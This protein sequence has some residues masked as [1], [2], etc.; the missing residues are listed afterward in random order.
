MDHVLQLKQRN[1]PPVRYV[2]EEADGADWLGAA[3]R[4]L[5]ALRSG[6]DAA[7]HARARRA[8]CAALRKT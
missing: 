2:V 3:G 7:L 5:A 8:L 1:G 4:A 6:A